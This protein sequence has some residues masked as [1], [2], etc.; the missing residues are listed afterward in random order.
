MRAFKVEWRPRR[1][2]RKRVLAASAPPSARPPGLRGA[3][4]LVAARRRL[5]AAAAP[6]TRCRTPSRAECNVGTAE[7]GTDLPHALGCAPLL[8]PRYPAVLRSPPAGRTTVN[9]SSRGPHAAARGAPAHVARFRL[10]S[11]NVTVCHSA[12]ED[13]LLP[14]VV[15]GELH[16]YRETRISPSES[17]LQSM[18]AAVVCWLSGRGGGGGGLI[19][20]WTRG[21]RPWL[22]PAERSAV[23]CCSVD[24]RRPHE[25]PRPAGA[26]LGDR[27][28]GRARIL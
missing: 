28:A 3:A 24:W 20:C 16:R 25:P 10:L 21:G 23:L 2:G 19:L 9:A 6:V 7:C 17:G 27:T 22:R 14:N 5:H 26:P 15:C 12:A 8:R 11:P 18:N 1:R 13:G 4:A